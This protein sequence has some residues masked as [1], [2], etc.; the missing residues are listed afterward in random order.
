MEE[1]EAVPLDV[2]H[3]DHDH[4]VDP[5]QIGVG[6]EVI[7]KEQAGAGKPQPHHHNAASARSNT[8]SF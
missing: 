6:L 7:A 2:P 8:R 1:N 5:Q 4:P 3:V